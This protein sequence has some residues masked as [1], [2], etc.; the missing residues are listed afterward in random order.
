MRRVSGRSARLPIQVA[1]TRSHAVEGRCVR[2]LP[3]RSRQVRNLQREQ[4]GLRAARLVDSGPGSVQYDGQRASSAGRTPVA[5]IAGVATRV[6]MGPSTPD[7]VPWSFYIWNGQGEGCLRGAPVEQRFALQR[8]CG[9]SS[10][11]L[12]YRFARLLWEASDKPKTLKG[13]V[14]AVRIQRCV[15]PADISLSPTG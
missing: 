9:C 1:P 5:Q 3:G 4:S 13:K 11:C 10:R 7:C 6:P 14:C 2:P 15:N 12:T 8:P